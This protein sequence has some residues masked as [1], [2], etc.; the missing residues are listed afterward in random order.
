MVFLEN[1]LGAWESNLCLEPTPEQGH[2]GRTPE[3]CLRLSESAGPGLLGA[4]SGFPLPVG[5]SSQTLF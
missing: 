3:T 2:P 5:L 4:L 1:H